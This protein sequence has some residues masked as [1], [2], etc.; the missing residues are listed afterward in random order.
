[1]FLNFGWVVFNIDGSVTRNGGNYLASCGG[2]FRG[3]G[4]ILLWHL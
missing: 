4:T 2:D 1:M 3:D